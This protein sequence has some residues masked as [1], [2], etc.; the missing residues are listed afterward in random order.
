MEPPATSLLIVSTCLFSVWG[1]SNREIEEK[2]IFRPEN[3]LA[4]KEYYRLVTSALLHANWTHLLANMYSLY[5]FGPTI[6]LL[7]GQL[8]FLLIYFGSVV[9]GSLLSLYLHRNHDYA[10]YGA[11]GGVCGMIFAYVV[12]FPRRSIPIFPLP[13]AVPARIH[14]CLLLCDESSK[15][16]HRSRCASRR[17]H[18]R[19]DHRIGAPPGNCATQLRALPDSDLDLP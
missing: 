2:C 1:F 15:G 3:I 5:C 6:E 19:T 4:R 16:P 17:S 12:M 9:G 10:A 8:H 11:S 18:H 14:D 7:F 13:L